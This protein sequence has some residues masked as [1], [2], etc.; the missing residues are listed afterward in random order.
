[1]QNK[2]TGHWWL[3]TLLQTIQ[4]SLK[5]SEGPID[6]YL[7]PDDCDQVSPVKSESL[8]CESSASEDETQLD[9][10]YSDGD[11]LHKTGIHDVTFQ[12]TLECSLERFP[13]MDEE[14]LIALSPF[15]NETDYTYS[16]TEEEGLM[17]LYDIYDLKPSSPMEFLS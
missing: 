4:L 2:F 5:S 14:R 15:R 6:V 16:L 1:M 3:I 10:Q 17:D 9:H 13:E 11:M 7:C 8:S 12:E